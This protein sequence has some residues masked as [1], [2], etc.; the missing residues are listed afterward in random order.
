MIR[1]S[2]FAITLALGSAYADGP[3][4][5][6]TDQQALRTIVPRADGFDVYWFR[7]NELREP[8]VTR[9][10]RTSLDLNGTVAVPTKL[11]TAPAKFNLSSGPALPLVYWRPDLDFSRTWFAA[12]LAAA[13]P[14]PEQGSLFAADADFATIHCDPSSCFARWQESY[15]AK[16]AFLDLSGNIVSGPFPLPGVH[17]DH[18]SVAFGGDGVVS[19]A[20]WLNGYSVVHV[21]RDGTVRYDVPLLQTTSGTGAIVHDGNRAIVAYIPKP[22]PE[23]PPSLAVHALAI[24]SDGQVQQLGPLFAP[25]GARYLTG[26]AMAWNGTTHLLVGAYAEGPENKIFA[27]ELDRDLRVIASAA[28]PAPFSHGGRF[29]VTPNGEHFAIGWSTWQPMVAVYHRGQISKP[30][31]LHDVPGPRRRGARH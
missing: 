27:V 9:L 3:I 23:T 18:A 26:L 1:A 14:S 28:I 22:W 29:D 5:S 25:A 17:Y 30:V 12:S 20:A 24:S 21:G 31:T 10:L 16:G 11:I 6:P 4:T 19:I 15:G 7:H 2:L 8:V 13:L